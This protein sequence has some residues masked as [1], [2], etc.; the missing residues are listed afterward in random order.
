MVSLPCLLR[1]AIPSPVRRYF[2]YLPPAGVSPQQLQPGSRFRVPFGKRTV[3]GILVAVVTQSEIAPDRL[4][5]A[6]ACLDKVPIIPAPL[7]RL[8]TWA[9]RYY[10]HPPGEVF[11]T[12]LPHLLRQ[13]KPASPPVSQRW[14][15]K[16]ANY[17]AAL[18][19]APR[20][21]QLAELLKYHPQGLTASQIKAQL[22][23]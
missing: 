17:G 2:D 4:K 18:V 9:A 16:E 20:Q 22:G 11:F 15:L 3:I 13:G 23:A 8:L 7:L 19:R 10:H 21:Q 5:Q 6:H 1:L 12:A 14:L